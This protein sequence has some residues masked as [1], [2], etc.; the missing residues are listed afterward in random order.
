MAH[1]HT[2]QR[3]GQGEGPRRA[4]VLSGGG[5]RAVWQVGACQHLIAERGY[6]FDV[7]AGVSAG[8]VNGAT[9][10]QAR[11][12]DDLAAE[13]EHL[14]AVW[15]GI[16]GNRD[17]YGR[18]WLGPLGMVLGRR[19]S[20]HETGPLRRVLEQHIDPGRV[21][22]SPIG[23]RVG[24]VDLLSGRYRTAGNDD[25]ALVDAVLASC[26]VP[27]FFPPVPL[28][29]GRELGVDGG[30]RNATP[31]SDALRALSER[32]ARGVEPD[33]V[34]VLVP[35]PL[36]RVSEGHVRDWWDVTRRSLSVLTEEAFA[37]NIEQVQD[38]PPAPVTLRV[39]HPREELRGP[40]L[41]FAPERLRHW[42]DD[43]LQAAR[44]VRVAESAA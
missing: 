33:E 13:L 15:F 3:A 37:G 20:L 5:A 42:Y 17:I 6:W 30:V 23:L 21:A 7:I 18:R 24:Y 36:R 16:R 19:A 28:R 40:I 32:P 9:L 2:K 43:G 26:A 41:D 4:L 1:G 35:R 39:L 34:W 8:A 12:L 29:D 25:P 11:D 44:E 22:A 10:A 38:E 14:R 27:L 31:V